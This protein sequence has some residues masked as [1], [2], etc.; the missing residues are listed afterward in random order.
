MVEVTADAA[1]A[2]KVTVS[3]IP[4]AGLVRVRVF[5]SA[6]EVFKVQVETPE[7]FVEEQLLRVLPLPEEV[8]TGVTE[9]IG[10]EKASFSVMVT[11]AKS[12]LSA[13]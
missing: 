1:P 8:N 7:A 10:F 3:V 11:V 12:E 6:V 9:E 5:T 4:M 13:V 2:L